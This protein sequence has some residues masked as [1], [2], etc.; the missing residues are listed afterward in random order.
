MAPWRR[1]GI[2]PGKYTVPANWY[3]AKLFGLMNLFIEL[4][5]MFYQAAQLII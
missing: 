1:S 2:E 4:L 5:G 3:T